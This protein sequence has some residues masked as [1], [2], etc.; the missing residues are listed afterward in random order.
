M[1]NDDLT[2][3]DDDLTTQFNHAKDDQKYCTPVPPNCVLKF[4]SASR[5]PRSLMTR[6]RMERGHFDLLGQFRL[7]NSLS[8]GVS[9]RPDQICEWLTNLPSMA[10]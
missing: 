7:F 1:K 2:M 6:H 3:Q 5:P 4:E 8:Y 10:N 9:L